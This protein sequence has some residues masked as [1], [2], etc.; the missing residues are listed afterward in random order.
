[1][2]ILDFQAAPHK[3]NITRIA[4]QAVPPCFVIIISL[5]NTAFCYTGSFNKML[6]SYTLA[7]LVDE[8]HTF[9]SGSPH[10][11]PSFDFDRALY[12]DAIIVVN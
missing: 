12:L 3:S 5:L 4:N 1:L 10:S 8:M 2:E 9:A 6:R 11:C 7:M